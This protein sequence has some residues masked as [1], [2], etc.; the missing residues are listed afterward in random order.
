M[1]GLNLKIIDDFTFEDQKKSENLPKCF[2]LIYSY[3]SPTFKSQDDILNLFD[4]KDNPDFKLIKRTKFESTE[5][6]LF[7]YKKEYPEC[8]NLLKRAKSRK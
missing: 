4:V 7:S 5:A 8:K 6:V 1:L 2:W 3:Y